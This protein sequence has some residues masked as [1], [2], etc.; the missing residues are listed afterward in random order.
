MDQIYSLTL[1]VTLI[2]GGLSTTLALY[3]RF[4]QGAYSRWR[5][6]AVLAGIT[7]WVM[8]GISI[9]VHV[10]YGHRPGTPDAL[11]PVDFVSIHPAYLLALAL[12]GAGVVLSALDA[13]RSR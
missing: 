8:A 5:R 10:A 9:A 12:G 13:R 6:A 7:S 2:A 11:C 1:L 3:L 4:R